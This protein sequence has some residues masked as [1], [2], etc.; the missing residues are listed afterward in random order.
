MTATRHYGHTD[1]GRVRAHNEDAFLADSSLGLFVVCDG[2]G[3]RARG[4]IA[5][6]ETVEFIHDWIKSDA[7][8]IVAARTHDLDAAGVQRLGSLVRGA[9][10]NACYM[11]HS[12]GELD[13]DRRGMS[14]TASVVLIASGVAIVGW[15]GDSRVYLGRPGQIRQLTDDHTLV[16]FQVKQ[17]VIT[18]DQARHSKMKHVITR[19]VGHRDHVEVDIRTVPL[20]H[21]DKL[22]LCSDGLHEYLDD[23]SD[24][25]PSLFNKAEVREAAREAIRMANASGGRDNITALFVEYLGPGA[26]PG[27][28]GV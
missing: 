25:L 9:V 14:T 26:V 23:S 2:V 19:A 18:A 10:Q 20:Q 13:P 4:E 15:V 1:T 27:K 24:M 12:M 28:L 11:V 3:G 16:N 17:G 6:Q 21:G 5:S 8:D 22:L 7:G